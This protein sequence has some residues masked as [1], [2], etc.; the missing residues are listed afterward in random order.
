VRLAKGIAGVFAMCSGHDVDEDVHRCETQAL[1]DDMQSFAA[2][3]GHHMPQQPSHVPSPAYPE[4]LN[5]W[6]QQEYGVPFITPEDETEDYDDSSYFKSTPATTPGS[7]PGDPRPSS[8][9][10]PPPLPPYMGPCSSST[11]PPFDD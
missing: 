8:S 11:N 9:A 7:I 5:E 10:H 6:H 1:H 2:S 3:M 4:N